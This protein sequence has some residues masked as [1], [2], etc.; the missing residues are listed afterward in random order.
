MFSED[1]TSRYIT[2]SPSILRF[3]KINDD[4][5]HDSSQQVSFYRPVIHTRKE[6]IL[7]LNSL[8]KLY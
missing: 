6:N 1:L 8:C 3:P 2:R 5:M 7:K 4:T